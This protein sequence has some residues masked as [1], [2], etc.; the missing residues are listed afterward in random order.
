MLDRRSRAKKTDAVTEVNDALRRRSE[1]NLNRSLAASRLGKTLRQN[2]FPENRDLGPHR[3]PGTG[4][5]YYSPA[6][7]THLLANADRIANCDAEAFL[8]ASA[9]AS[10][11]GP[12]TGVSSIPDIESVPARLRPA[13]QKNLYALCMDHEMP[14]DAVMVKTA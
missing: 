14:R 3:T 5:I 1:K 4:S 11:R 7:V 8:K 13:D 12:L 6:Y 2:I 10:R 9:K